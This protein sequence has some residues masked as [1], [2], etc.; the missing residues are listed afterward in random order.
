V[1]RRFAILAALAACASPSSDPGVRVAQL[2]VPAI[3]GAGAPLPAPVTLEDP[4]GS[5]APFYEALARAAAGDPSGRVLIAQYGDSHTAGDKLTGRMRAVLQAQFGDAGRGFVLPGRPKIKHYY[6]GDVRYG[7]DGAWKSDQGGKRGTTE[8]YGLAGVRSYAEASSAV[9][10]VETCSDCKAGTAVDSFEI[11][12]LR[13]PDGG[14]LEARVDD[15]EWI[16]IQTALGADQGDAA[17]PDYARIE[18]D[19]GPHRLSLRPRGSKEVDVFGIA[20]ERRVPGV[21]V[22]ALGIVGV[23]MSHLWKWDWSVISAQL[24]R[25]DPALVVLQ[26]GTNEVDDKDLDLARF[27]ERYVELVGRVRTA[28]PGAAILILGPPDMAVRELG[29]KKCERLAKAAR[30][31]RKKKSGVAEVPDGCQWRTPAKL[32]DIIAAERRVATRTGVAF[33]DSLE[34][35]GGRD[36]I[37]ALVKADPPLAYQDHVHFTGRG[38][39]AWADLLLEDLNR[40]YATWEKGA[41]SAR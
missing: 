38:Y 10:W 31:Q 5:L 21:I 2:P 4:K 15:G 13:Q 6:L 30:N 26:Y 37:D 18:V 19:D 9:A 14:V 33:F 27:E 34:A 22:D 25:R 41:V 20:L 11:F 32:L 23:Q 35:M 8:P 39:A 24:A 28:V 3:A 16:R 40:G 17:V 1:S 29:S 36:Q 12:F 7:T